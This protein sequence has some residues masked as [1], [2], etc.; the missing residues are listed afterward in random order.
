MVLSVPALTTGT[1]FTVM[2]AESLPESLLS[3]AVSFN[4]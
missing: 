2:T 1:L 4:V 3:F